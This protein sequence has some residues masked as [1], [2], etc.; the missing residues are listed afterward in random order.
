MTLPLRRV[1][2]DGAVVVLRD[3][4]I[5]VLVGQ[6]AVSVVAAD[7][8]DLRPL[9]A[10]GDDAGDRGDRVVGRRRWERR[11][12]PRGGA[13][14]GAP[15][16]RR[17]RGAR[18]GSAS[19]SRRRRRPVVASCRWRSVPGSRDPAPP[20]GWRRAAARFPARTSAALARMSERDSRTFRF[21]GTSSM[22]LLRVNGARVCTGVER[23]KY[24]K[25]RASDDEDREWTIPVRRAWQIRTN[26]GI[27]TGRYRRTRFHRSG[28]APTR[29]TRSGDRRSPFAHRSSD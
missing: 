21:M 28:D 14:G 27:R 10:R 12:V 9:L 5:A 8:P 16:G 25:N 6:D 26:G 7:L 2:D 18:G 3:Q 24:Y 22:R 17:R 19:A 15:P 11:R 4:Q 20:A 1:S 29:R 23:H 13:G